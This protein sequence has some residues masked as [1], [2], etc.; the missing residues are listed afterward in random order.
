[1]R[2][3][4]TCVRLIPYLVLLLSRLRRCAAFLRR[5]HDSQQPV[6]LVLGEMMMRIPPPRQEPK[7][8]KKKKNVRGKSRCAQGKSSKKKGVYSQ[9]PRDLR[10]RRPRCEITSGGSGREEARE[11]QSKEERRRRRRQRG[12]RERGGSSASLY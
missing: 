5:G 3:R 2:G 12:E 7:I 6:L 4:K 9:G 11:S 1:M 8:Q 10:L